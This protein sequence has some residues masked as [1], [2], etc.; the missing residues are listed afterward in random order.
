MLLGA[1]LGVEMDIDKFE[2]E[3][4]AAFCQ[5]CMACSI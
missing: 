5:S 4:G 1:A 2:R 3:N